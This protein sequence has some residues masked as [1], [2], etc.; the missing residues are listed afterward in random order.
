MGRYCFTE[1]HFATRP[2]VLRLVFSGTLAFVQSVS[3]LIV[4]LEL[5]KAA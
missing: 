1:S 2:L 3:W 4:I 5:Y